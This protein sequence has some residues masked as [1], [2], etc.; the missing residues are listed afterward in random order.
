MLSQSNDSICYLGHCCMEEGNFVGCTVISLCIVLLSKKKK[1]IVKDQCGVLVN[2]MVRRSDF[3]PLLLQTSDITPRKNNAGLLQDWL[4]IEPSR[5]EGTTSPSERTHVKKDFFSG[6]WDRMKKMRS[7]SQKSKFNTEVLGRPWD[8][9][10]LVWIKSGGCSGDTCTNGEQT[11]TK[12]PA[13]PPFLLL[14]PTL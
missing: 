7:R 14:F 2:L 9:V 4:I 10:F 6:F 12:W 1:S 5:W 11:V 8:A 13:G 3:A